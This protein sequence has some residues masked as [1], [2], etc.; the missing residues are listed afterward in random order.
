MYAPV[1]VFVEMLALVRPD[2]DEFIRVN[3]ENINPLMKN[4]FVKREHGDADF[5]TTGSVNSGHTPYDVLSAHK[6]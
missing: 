4:N 5:F 2:R 3:E 6:F 1:L